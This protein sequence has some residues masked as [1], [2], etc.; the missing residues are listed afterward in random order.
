ME[1]NKE[2]QELNAK[3]TDQ[4]IL[5]QSDR[6]IES[7]ETWYDAIAANDKNSE[8]MLLMLESAV[9]IFTE[10]RA[11]YSRTIGSPQEVSRDTLREIENSILTILKERLE[12]RTF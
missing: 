9:S 10:L 11:R 8:Q 5:D 12:N 4:D 7:L 3:K 6:A 1:Q 2:L